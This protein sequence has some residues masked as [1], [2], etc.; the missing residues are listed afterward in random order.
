MPF[1]P[2]PR[3]EDDLPAPM[4]YSLC[5]VQMREKGEMAASTATTTRT[6]HPYRDLDVIDARAP[7]F[8]QA[9][10]GVLSTVALATGWWWLLG[11]LALQLIVGLRFGR[12]WCLPCVFYFEVVQPR[13]G[14]GE[15][16]DA[17][18]P[19]FA[20]IVGAIFLSAATAAHIVGLSTLG[21]I[22]AGIVAALALLA[23]ATGICVGCEMYKMVAR[24]RGIRPGSVE[25]ID[26]SE[27]GGEGPAQGREIE[28][29]HFT[30]PLC[31]G[32]REL[33]E[34]LTS[35]GQSLAVVDVS[36]HPALARRY[37]VSVV[38]TTY[39]VG[40]DGAVTGRLA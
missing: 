6:A 34:R 4:I 14:E 36:Q 9:T 18:P 40:A 24:M 19:R 33:E 22:L 1:G 21:W 12:R 23:A 20:N 7:R 8:N 26:L 25:H 5:F 10:V 38:P 3:F 15:I 32:C 27:V 31:S 35:E 17:R 2:A 37:H 11:L 39:E 16:E 30:H 13:R 28:V 29:V